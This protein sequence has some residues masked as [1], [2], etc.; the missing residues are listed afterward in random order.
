MTKDNKRT[1]TFREV[2]VVR[3]QVSYSFFFSN[4]IKDWMPKVSEKRNK[5]REYAKIHGHSKRRI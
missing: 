4:E 1:R 5:Q 2:G 3:D